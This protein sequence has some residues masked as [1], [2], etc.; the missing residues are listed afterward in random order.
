MVRRLVGRSL[1]KEAEVKPRTSTQEHGQLGS[2]QHGDRAD[3][4]R[5]VAT[6]A[7]CADD[8]SVLECLRSAG[9]GLTMRQLQARTK[10]SVVDPEAVLQ[11]LVERKLVSR[12]NTLIPTYAVSAWRAKGDRR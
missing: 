1:A 2:Q 7:L 12:L 11:R 5:S 6:E 4:E 8:E 9:S 10:D 3:V